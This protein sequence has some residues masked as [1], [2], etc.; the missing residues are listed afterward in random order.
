MRHEHPTAQKTRG[1]GNS[2]AKPLLTI[3]PDRGDFGIRVDR[4][5]LRHLQQIPGVTRNR[6]QR[7]IESGAV[8]IN[9][10]PVPRSATRIAPGDLLTVDMP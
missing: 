8:Q 2:E 4:V 7:L 3:E 9:G 1:G 5:L 6:L 10:R